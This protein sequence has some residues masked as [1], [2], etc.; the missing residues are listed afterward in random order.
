[1]DVRGLSP[2]RHRSTTPSGSP[3]VARCGSNAGLPSD[4]KRPVEQDCVDFSIERRGRGTQRINLQAVHGVTAGGRP[5]FASDAASDNIIDVALNE[6]VLKALSAASTLAA[7]PAEALA[8]AD[9]AAA[10][11]AAADAEAEAFA[12]AAKLSEAIAFRSSLATAEAS[13]E[14]EPEASMLT[15][16][17]AL[18]LARAANAATVLERLACGTVTLG[19][20]MAL[21]ACTKA[22][23]CAIGFGIGRGNPS[24]ADRLAK[25]RSCAF[26]AA[27]AAAEAEAEADADAEAEAEAEAL[28]E[29]EAEAEALALAEAFALAAAE[30]RAAASSFACNAATPPGAIRLIP[31]C[32]LT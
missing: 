32:L 21:I 27:E 10:A 24:A 13:A 15:P 23:S 5:T 18:M 12:V 11:E 16:S 20:C 28:A 3:T 26:I 9:A 4:G 8:E 14:T 29:A 6:P 2:S 1:M 19:T 25:A 17:P 30:A 22:L 7:K 31:N